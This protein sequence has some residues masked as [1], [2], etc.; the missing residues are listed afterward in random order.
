MIKHLLLNKPKINPDLPLF[1]LFK[2]QKVY[3]LV[4]GPKFHINR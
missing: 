2:P 4:C 3:E 1:F